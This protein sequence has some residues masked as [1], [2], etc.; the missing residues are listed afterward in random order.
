[1]RRRMP[2]RTFG[3]KRDILANLRN[4]AVTANHERVEMIRELLYNWEP[5]KPYSD[6]VRVASETQI[7]ELD[8]I[9]WWF[10]KPPLSPQSKC[11]L[12]PKIMRG[13]ENATSK[14]EEN[15]YMNLATYYGLV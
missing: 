2:V 1:M 7:D 13:I 4:R 11:V 14:T 5:L 9:R 10:K 6:L 15:M 3:T 12:Y 8:Y